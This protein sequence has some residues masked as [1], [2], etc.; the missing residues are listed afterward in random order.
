L[1]QA[2]LADGTIMTELKFLLQTEIILY[3]AEL[4]LQEVAGVLAKVLVG[5]RRVAAVLAAGHRRVLGLLVLAHLVKDSVAV[6]VPAHRKVAAAVAA[7]VHK[8]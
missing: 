8:V 4:L 3:L 6:I 7:Q 5:L 1:A 2:V